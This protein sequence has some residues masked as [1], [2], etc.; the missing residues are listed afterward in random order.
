VKI[1]DEDTNTSH[2]M[3]TKMSDGDTNTSRDLEVKMVDDDANESRDMEMKMADV[4]EMDICEEDIKSPGTPPLEPFM[5]DTAPE[6]SDT[7]GRRAVLLRNYS[8][9]DGHLMEGEHVRNVEIGW[10]GSCGAHS[11][12]GRIPIH[13]PAS[14]LEIIGTF[15]FLDLPGGGLRLL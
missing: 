7:Q 6:E 3:E 11:R 9:K 8:F 15:R 4:E 14:Y 13:V 12:G 5:L 1:A 2:D 10:E